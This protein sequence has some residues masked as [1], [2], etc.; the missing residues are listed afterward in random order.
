MNMLCSALPLV[1]GALALIGL[2]DVAR[3]VRR[4]L[5]SEA[6]NLTA[7]R[8]DFDD[9]AFGFAAAVLSHSVS[10]IEFSLGEACSLT[11]R[12]AFSRHYLSRAYG[13]VTSAGPSRLCR[14]ALRRC[15]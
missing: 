3:A 8:G 5:V 4:G 7:R 10:D 2:D 9:F 15:A 14:R 1:R 6:L 11:A 13:R 12:R